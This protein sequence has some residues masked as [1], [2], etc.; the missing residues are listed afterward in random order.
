MI[1]LS[2]SDS[3]DGEIGEKLQNC[4]LYSLVSAIFIASH[5]IRKNLEQNPVFGNY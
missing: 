5:E 4:C 3:V 2:N 1:T